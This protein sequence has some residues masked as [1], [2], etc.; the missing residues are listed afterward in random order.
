M[1]NLYMPNFIVVVP[2]RYP[3]KFHRIRAN[4]KYQYFGNLQSRLRKNQGVEQ[5]LEIRAY[6]YAETHSRVS[7]KMKL[8]C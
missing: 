3:A 4:K 7:N 2:G 6:S 5:S 8:Q 1:T